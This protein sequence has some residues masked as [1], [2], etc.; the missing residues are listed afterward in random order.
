LPSQQ[1]LEFGRKLLWKRLGGDSL[2]QQI[3]PGGVL[4]RNIATRNRGV[5]SLSSDAGI[6]Y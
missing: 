2:Q 1:A 3:D 4:T 5:Q 6:T